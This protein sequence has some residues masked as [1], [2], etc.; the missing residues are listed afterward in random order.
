MGLNAEVFKFGS[1]TFESS[2]YICV[3]DAA[4]CAIIDTTKNFALERKPMKAEGI[5][6]HRSKNIIALRAPSGNN[7]TIQVFDL[8][9]KAKVKQCEIKETVRFWRWIDEDTLGVVGK[10]GVYHTNIND[11]NPP[12]KIFDQEGKFANSQIMN[13]GVDASKTWCYLVGIYP[14]QNNQICGH[15]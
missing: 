3:K 9:T 10:T 8:D 11:Q 6:M 4:D 14:G 2:K 7:T 1:I 13:Y 5:L 12:N 15:M